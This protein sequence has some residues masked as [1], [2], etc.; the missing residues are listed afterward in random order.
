M[1]I[2]KWIRNKWNK[3]R[4]KPVDIP[5]QVLEKDTLEHLMRSTLLFLNLLNDAMIKLN[6]SRKQRRRVFNDFR[7]R[8]MVNGEIEKELTVLMKPLIEGVKASHV[9][10]R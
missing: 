8:G 6:Y 10:R 1:K 7:D 5:K 3:F 2:I 4:K 9:I